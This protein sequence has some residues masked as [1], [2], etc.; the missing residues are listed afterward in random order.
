MNRR[1]FLS[2]LGLGAAGAAVAQEVAQRIESPAVHPSLRYINP[3]TGAHPYAA[4]VPAKR[5]NIFVITLDMVSPE[6]YH[7]SR[8][9]A[10]EVNLPTIQSLKSDGVLFTNSFCTAPLC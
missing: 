7:P 1:T 4:K 3:K 2:S 10:R 9:L 6:H 8:K 5:P